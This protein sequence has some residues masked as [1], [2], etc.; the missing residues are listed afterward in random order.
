[1]AHRALL[2]FRQP[3]AISAL[4]RLL[5]ENRLAH[6]GV[7]SIVLQSCIINAIGSAALPQNTPYIGARRRDVAEVVPGLLLACQSVRASVLD[8]GDGHPH[9]TGMLKQRGLH[10]AGRTIEVD[11]RNEAGKRFLARD[12]AGR[13]CWLNAVVL[14]L[15][16][17]GD[18]RGK[19]LTCRVARIRREDQRH[20]AAIH[21]AAGRTSHGNTLRTASGKL[22]NPFLFRNGISSS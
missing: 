21:A 9:A 5:P 6:V 19:P 8:P 20:V 3:H 7:C 1:M 12:R 18:G 4:P 2:R 14:A 11:Q 16:A 17:A 22:Q 13:K 10:R 15:A